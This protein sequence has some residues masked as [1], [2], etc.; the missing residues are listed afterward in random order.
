MTGKTARPSP[1][2]L[3]RCPMRFAAPPSKNVSKNVFHPV[4]YVDQQGR[5]VNAILTSSSS[6][7]ILKK[8]CGRASF[9]TAIETSK[10]IL[11]CRSRR[12]IPLINNLF[13]LHGRDR[14]T[15]HPGSAP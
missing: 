5:P 9:P 2:S 8:A 3:A 14:F 12:Q 6:Q 11:S 10:G 7:K 4:F 13:W 1:L 15:P